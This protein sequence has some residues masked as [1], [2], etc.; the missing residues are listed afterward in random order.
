M[1][2][3]TDKV[4]AMPIPDGAEGVYFDGRA[5]IG[6]Y[7]N[8]ELR[9]IHLPPGTWRF[10]FATKTATEEDASKVVRELPVGARYENYNGDYP[11]WYHTGRESLRSL[12]R[13]KG[14]D[15]K[16]NYAIIE[17]ETTNE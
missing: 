4:T 12:L 16:N 9:F 13:S 5:S 3:L 14:L 15:D 11:I 8:G 2:Q 17:K 10:L 1:K 6:F 7:L